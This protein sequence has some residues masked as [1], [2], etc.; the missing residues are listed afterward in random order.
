MGAFGSSK[1]L[2]ADYDYVDPTTGEKLKGGQLVFEVERAQ[3]VEVILPAIK[4]EK[5]KL[6]FIIAKV[7]FHFV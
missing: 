7:K 4:V 1:C 2:Q 5:S 3:E 6:R